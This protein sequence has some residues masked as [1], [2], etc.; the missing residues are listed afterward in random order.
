MTF[1]SG[2]KKYRDL[3]DNLVSQM[4]EQVKLPRALFKNLVDCSLSGDGYVENLQGQGYDFAR[5]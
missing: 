5:E 3:G 2:S 4:A 1:G